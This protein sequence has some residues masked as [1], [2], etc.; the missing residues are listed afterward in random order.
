MRVTGERVV[1][2][3]RGQPVAELGPATK[4]LARYPQ[5]ELE[6]TATLLTQDRR[7]LDA[8]LTPTL[9]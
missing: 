3:K 6:G 4:A 8:S 7:I 1:I 5:M 2:L 9:G